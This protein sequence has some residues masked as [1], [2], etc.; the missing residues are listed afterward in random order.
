M[1]TRGKP[2]VVD[3]PK[4]LYPLI[5][6]LEK[7]QEGPGLT[8]YMK[9]RLLSTGY[10]EIVKISPP[11][12]GRPKEVLQRNKR[13]NAVIQLMKGWERRKHQ[14]KKTASRVA[15]RATTSSTK[16]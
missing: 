11:G 6:N 14:V 5:A 4:T 12:R 15:R 1:N 2:S 16:H 10:T 13:G 8:H 3:D 7:L 9:Q